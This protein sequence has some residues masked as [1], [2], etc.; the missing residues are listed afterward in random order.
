M[1]DDRK[2][3]SN[4]K[5]AILI[6]V[7]FVVVPLIIF[8]VVNIFRKNHYGDELKI[9]NFSN[10]FSNVPGDTRD[11]VFAGL[12]DVVVSNINNDD[13]IPESGALIREGSWEEIY[14]DEYNM[15]MGSFIVDIASIKQSYSGYFK[16]SS[17]NNNPYFFGNYVGFSCLKE[18]EI[19]YKDFVCRDQNSD[20]PTAKF[21]ITNVLPVTVEYYSDNY[22]S[23]TKYF[24]SYILKD[25][26]TKIVLKITD[27]T[28]GNYDKALDK[29]RELGFDPSEYAI[30]YNDVS[31][32]YTSVY[33]GD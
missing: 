6:I 32:K 7:A 1:E 2:Y 28:G 31:E 25:D 12:Y 9:D 17:D 11:K 14:D 10:I 33:V 23:Y 4:K 20:S 24:I 5:I 29:I 22:S 26:N 21:P 8:L 3:E 15:H 30:E 18:G 19:I 27:Y 16:W 13:Q